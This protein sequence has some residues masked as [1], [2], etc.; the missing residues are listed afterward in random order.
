MKVFDD[1]DATWQRALA[2]AW[3]AHLLGNIG[4]GAVLTDQM[5]TIVA[6]GRNRVGDT[7]APPGRL[8]GT[9]LA[10]A[11]MDVLA[12]LAVGDYEHHTIW[13]TLQPCLLCMS[14]VVTTH[15]GFVRFM[16]PDPLWDGIE[17]LPEL[18]PQAGKRWPDV[19][20]PL[21]TP[22]ASFCA[23][24]P[25]VWFFQRQGGGA[26]VRSYE[27]DYPGL[28]ALAH[29]LA[30]ERTLDPWGGEPVEVILERLWDDLVKAGQ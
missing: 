19:V 5:G 9:Y 18:N 8:H 22:F 23:M 24:L 12:Q 10:H 4:V 16:A 26:A 21:G 30:D 14:A 15:V 1:L 29:R 13:T 3:R 7:S 2:Q 25:M 20:G 28:V 6:E 11:E 27:A 17:K